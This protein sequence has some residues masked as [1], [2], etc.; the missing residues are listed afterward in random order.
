MTAPKPPDPSEPTAS[1]DEERPRRGQGPALRPR[2][3]LLYHPELAR[4]GQAT[5]DW[6]PDAEG[7]VTVGRLAPSFEGADASAGPLND[8]HVSRAQFRL[9]WLDD[10]AFE[11]IPAEGPRLQLQ[12]IAPDSSA[13]VSVTARR[14]VPAGSLL[15]LGRRALLRLAAAPARDASEDRL[16]LVGEGEAAWALRGRIHAVAR[17]R[18]PVLILG[19][20]GSGKELVARAVHR[21]GGDAGAF[22]ALNMGG[23]DAGTAGSEL[24]GHVRG[25][26][27]GAQGDRAGA[28]EAARH[29]TLFLDEIGD[30]SPDVQKKLLRVLEDRRFSPLGSHRT[31]PLE[32][33]VLAATHCPLRDDVESGHFRRD[34]F[35][36]LQALTIPVPPLRQRREDVPRLFVTFLAALRQRHPE[37]GS[38][39]TTTPRG[40]APVPMDFFVG[41]L[42]HPW[43]G[44]VREL[45]NLAT[46]TAAAT[47]AAGSFAPGELAP[48]TSAP[49]PA[50]AAPREAV[51]IPSLEALEETLSGC[52]GNVRAAAA[53]F[54]CSRY[55]LYRWMEARGLSPDRFRAQDAS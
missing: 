32:C 35:E 49:S 44:N 54:G 43:P 2:L 41:L 46:A 16:G 55:Q 52:R 13:P 48:A 15:C 30:L 12:L 45:R 36:R 38:L 26:F 40:P 18:E 33:R 50:P 19:E 24:F 3:E 11:V 23:L 27:T 28:F 51:A 5:T 42:R 31:A 29:G 47:L 22:V 7:L 20:T 37:L 34:L 10:G 25:A 21:L 4:I 17:F 9:R 14:V 1:L 39:W 53:H 6:T 8:P